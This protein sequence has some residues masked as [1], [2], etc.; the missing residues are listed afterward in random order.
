MN[1]NMLIV[2]RFRHCIRP[3]NTCMY[4]VGKCEIHDPILYNYIC[5]ADNI[6][7]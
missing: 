7:F 3:R 6:V 4:I 1:I 2:F 5:K